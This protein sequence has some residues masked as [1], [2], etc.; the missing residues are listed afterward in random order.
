MLEDSL[1]ESRDRG[2]TRKPFTV[3]VAIAA[4]VVTVTLLVLIPLLET[5]AVP[6]P[7]A[8]SVP[9][10]A[11]LRTPDAGSVHVFPAQH[12]PHITPVTDALTEP[13]SIPPKIVITD[14]STG[15]AIIGLLAPGDGS[16]MLSL[17][18][19]ANSYPSN[20]APVPLD[21]PPPPP[22]PAPVIKN[23][24]PVRRGGVIQAANL[25]QQVKPVYPVLAQQTRVEGVVVMEA[26][27]SKEGSV[28]SLR[29]ISGHPLLNKA[30]LDAVQQWKYRPTLLNGEPV[31]VLTTITVTFTLR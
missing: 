20:L 9:L 27:I 16:T 29:V 8:N 17:P 4:H 5:H 25:I 15:P 12:R 7:S 6:L 26:V 13:T 23:T 24:Q 3:A 21:V 31:E 11:S 30:A 1:F 18:G 14:D 22:P 19:L 10:P 28:E 2:K